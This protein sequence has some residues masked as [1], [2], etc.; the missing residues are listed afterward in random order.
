MRLLQD[1][2]ADGIDFILTL[3]QGEWWIG[4]GNEHDDYPAETRVSLKTWPEVEAW[5]IDNVCR[6]YPD[7]T[8]AQKY[9]RHTAV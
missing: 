5:L 2:Q 6:H 8:F 1:L 9:T 4:L 7:S 3:A